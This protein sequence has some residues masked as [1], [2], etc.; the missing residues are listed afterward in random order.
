MESLLCL[1]LILRLREIL[2]SYWC[3]IKRENY[4]GLRTS[5]GSGKKTINNLKK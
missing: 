4:E 5:I 3:H 2:N 1:T